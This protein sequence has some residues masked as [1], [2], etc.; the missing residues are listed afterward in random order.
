MSVDDYLTQLRG[1]VKSDHFGAKSANWLAIRIVNLVSNFLNRGK[2][3]PCN[4]VETFSERW[5]L[6][7]VGLAGKSRDRTDKKS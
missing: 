1:L 3:E 5:Q 4:E 2:T 7:I 6:L